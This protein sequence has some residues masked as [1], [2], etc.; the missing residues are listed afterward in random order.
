MVHRAETPHPVP[1]PL[2]ACRQAGGEG[3]DEGARL[4]R[5]FEFGVWR[6][7]GLPARSRFGEGRD[8][9]FGIWILVERKIIAGDKDI[10]KASVAKEKDLSP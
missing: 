3:G 7:F 1:L 10:E 4:F 8:L 5:S 9:D 2:P 6:L